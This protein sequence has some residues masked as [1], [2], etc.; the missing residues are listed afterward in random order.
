MKF[1]P[2][3]PMFTWPGLGPDA[4]SGDDLPFPDGAGGRRGAL[5]AR[6]GRP[7]RECGV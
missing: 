7:R 6:L 5:T 2:T 4:L 3:V 1:G